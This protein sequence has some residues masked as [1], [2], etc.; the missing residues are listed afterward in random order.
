MK[1]LGFFPRLLLAF[2]L[3][4]IVAGGALLLVGLALG[5]AFLQGHLESMGITHH[6]VP[7]DTEAMLTDLNVGYQQALTQSLLWAVLAALVVAGGLSFFISSQ[8]ARPLTQMREVTRRIATGKYDERVGYAGPGEVG[9]LATDFNM[10]ATSLQSAEMQRAELVR[11]LAHEFRT[12]VMNLRGYVEGIEDGIFELN[13]ETI[14][15]TKRQLERIERL[16]NDLALLSRVDANQETVKPEKVLLSRLCLTAAESVRPQ[17]LQK[18]VALKVGSI[19]EESYVIADP[20]RTGQVL[21]NLLANALRHTD[22]GGEV[23]L[24]ASEEIDD[25]AIHVKDT[26]EGIAADALAHIFT[27]FYRT[28]TSSGGTG[29]G[30]TIANYF[31]EAQGGALYVES[32]AGEGSHFWFTLPKT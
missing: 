30:L 9:E 31:V 14:S 7:A 24:W 3:V 20:I 6:N 11:N 16:M 1:S 26:G 17:F 5:P 28:E 15:A 29:I 27:R 10:M 18:G 19:S 4:I 12:P 8:V 22:E 23:K 32:Q 25:A 21:S 2:F 13:A